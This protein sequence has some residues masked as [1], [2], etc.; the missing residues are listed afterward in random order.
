MYKTTGAISVESCLSRIQVC[1]RRSDVELFMSVLSKQSF[2]VST[3]DVHRSTSSSL[4]NL[5]TST[6][7]SRWDMMEA[8]QMEP[9]FSDGV[10]SLQTVQKSMK[11]CSNTYTHD[12]LTP[13]VGELDEDK[14]TDASQQATQFVHAIFATQ[15]TSQ[16][17]GATHMRA[18]EE[19]AQSEG[20]N[21]YDL[22]GTNTVHIQSHRRVL[23]ASMRRR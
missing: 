1:V 13:Q 2:A 7:I 5:P 6:V 17:V 8:V 10:Q 14:T 21:K 18:T 11:V 3:L 22:D 12:G 19:A 20:A 15:Q 16:R 23:Y 4:R 9:T